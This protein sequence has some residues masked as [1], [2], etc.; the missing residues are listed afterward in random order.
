MDG[1]ELEKRVIR[2]NESIHSEKD[3][4][5]EHFHQTFQILYAMENDGEISLNGETYSFNRDQ[6][7]FITPYSNHSIFAHTKFAV[8]VLE[9]EPII[10]DSTIHHKLIEAYFNQ[11][12]IIKVNEFDAMEIRQLLRKMLYQQSLG[13]SLN[14]V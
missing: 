8:L 2:L 5:K 13:D 9:F 12:K 7:A 6:V 11:S 4:V 10:L 14:L 1:K 3:T